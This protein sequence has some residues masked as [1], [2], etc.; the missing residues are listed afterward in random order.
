[1]S[2][3]NLAGALWL[4]ANIGAFSVIDW[5]IAWPLVLIAGGA[6]LLIRRV[7]P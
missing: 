1:M 3:L 4:L 7:R 2:L 5:R 6:A